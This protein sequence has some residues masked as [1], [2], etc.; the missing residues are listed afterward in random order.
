MCKSKCHGMLWAWPRL[1]AVRRFDVKS[2]QILT[3][4]SLTNFRFQFCYSFLIKSTHTQTHNADVVD[5]R[6]DHLGQNQQHQHFNTRKCSFSRLFFHF[7]KNYG[8]VVSNIF[9]ASSM[10]INVE[11]LCAALR[12]I[13]CHEF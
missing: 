9:S 1:R 3:S 11:K 7:Q 5:G 13:A 4:L 2:R 12:S 6:W 10:S 8:R